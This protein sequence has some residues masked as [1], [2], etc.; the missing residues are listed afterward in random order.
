MCLPAWVGS[1][2]EHFPLATA[3]QCSCTDSLSSL[4]AGVQAKAG[5][6]PHDLALWR[7]QCWGCR[8]RAAFTAGTVVGVYPFCLAAQRKEVQARAVFYPLMG[9]GGAVNMCYRTLYIGTGEWPCPA[10]PEP[11]R[12]SLPLPKCLRGGDT[13]NEAT[14]ATCPGILPYPGTLESWWGRTFVTRLAS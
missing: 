5:P 10:H 4:G 9:L 12:L 2:E 1:W 13:E 7:A 8:G 11:G 3:E 6:S 14:G